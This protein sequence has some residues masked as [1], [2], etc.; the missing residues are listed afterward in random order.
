MKLN[1]RTFSAAL[2]LSLL[3]GSFLGTIQE[4][5]AQEASDTLLQKEISIEVNSTDALAIIKQ[6][7]I[8]DFLATT[9]S[10]SIEDIDV[11]NS[12]MLID[13]VDLT[14]VSTQ[15]ISILIQLKS[16][17]SLSTSFSQQTISASYNLNVVDTDSPELVLNYDTIQIQLGSTFD[18]QDA[19][20]S[21]TDNSGIDY[22]SNVLIT[23]TVDTSVLGSSTLTYRVSDKE[24][25]ETVKT[26][27]VQ[28]K[29]YYSTGGGFSQSDEINEML[30]L[31]N[32][33]R[34][35]YGLDPLELAD[36]AGQHAIAIRAQESIG[37]ITH[38]RPD[39]SHYKTALT[40]QGVEWDNSPL[41]ILTYAGHSIEG[42]LSWWMNSAGHRSILLEPDY[43]TIAIGQS[44]SMWAAILY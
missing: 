32:Q 15:R 7:V 37:N 21:V 31:I 3:A 19:I 26:V 33:T 24:N 38:R 41:E 6:T 30:A 43:K 12:E 27:F 39:G 34:A 20:K 2:I 17:G 9:D 18:P 5:E 10:L 23:G 29:E 40:E 42:S 28:I 1:H 16:V 11:E 4:V 25:N 8:E 22:S 36:E 13:H 14:T 35:S 44:G